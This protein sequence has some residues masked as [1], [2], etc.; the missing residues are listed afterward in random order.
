M[1]PCSLAVSGTSRSGLRAAERFSGQCSCLH[2]SEPHGKTKAY[3]LAKITFVI[4]LQMLTQ[5]IRTTTQSQKGKDKPSKVQNLHSGITRRF[6]SREGSHIQVQ[7][8]SPLGASTRSG[9]S[10][11]ITSYVHLMRKHPN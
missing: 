9:R 1:E 3:N 5:T 7:T 11:P 6:H 2:R 4:T 10:S 8:L